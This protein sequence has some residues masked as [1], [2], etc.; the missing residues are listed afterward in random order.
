MEI[1]RNSFSDPYIQPSPEF[2]H[3]CLDR[4]NQI[5]TERNANLD[6]SQIVQ[7][8]RDLSYYRP[9]EEEDKL[10]KRKAQGIKTQE[11]LD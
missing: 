11:E 3:A 1:F 9:K 7:I 8:L 6:K 2:H 10:K 5:I 4:I